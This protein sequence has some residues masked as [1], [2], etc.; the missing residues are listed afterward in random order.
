MSVGVQVRRWLPL[1]GL[2]SL[3]ACQAPE[4]A[5]PVPEPRPMARPED[6]G[7]SQ[8]QLRKARAERNRAANAAAAEALVKASATSTAQRDFYDRAERALRGQGRLR[9]DRVPLDAPID[10]DM[11]TRNF[12][13][14]AL[15]DEYAQGGMQAVDGGVPAPLRRW[16][17]P[18]RLQIEFGTTSDVA[19]RRAYRVEVSQFAARL[20]EV[21]GHRVSLTDSGGNFVVMVLSDDERRA[22]GPRLAQLV[23]GI[24]PQDIEVM[25]ALDADNFCT[26]FAYSRGATPV[27][28][29]AVALIRAE[30]PPLLQSSC[31]HEEVAQ[32]MGL[33]NDSPDARPSIFNDDE[34]FAL[35]TRHDELLLKI[36]YDPRLRPGMT[37]AEAEPVV[38]RIAS[39]LLAQSL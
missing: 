19:T 22:I 39:E 25:Q 35:L 8:E 28:S 27:Y 17:D 15:R 29:N 7:P 3:A 18:V 32:G 9:R 11:L 4:S 14:I 37:P 16:Q 2:L 38:R 21:T 12:I 6:L 23:P 33:A 20:A 24:P 1:L 10:A 30:L 26:V 31:I 5:S 34:E 36:L 13:A